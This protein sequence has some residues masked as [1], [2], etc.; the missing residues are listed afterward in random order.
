[1]KKGFTMIELIFVIVILGILAAVAIP[2][3]AATRND[4]KAASIK[5]DIGTAMQAI[6]SW[7]QGQ[8]E[9]SFLN[10][11]SLDT[12]VWTKQTKC[13]YIYSDDV[14]DTVTMGIYNEGNTTAIANC[15]V[16]ANATTRPYLGIKL[17]VAH[18]G[19]VKQLNDN[20]GVKDI[21]IT[22]GG[23]KVKF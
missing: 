21:N 19:I 18:D 20:M 22:L 3:L 10:A 1:M 2:K 16:D 15:D 5:T 14:G 8:K 7:F 17:S 13:Q 12:N 4:A 11:M 23:K 9:A 6:P